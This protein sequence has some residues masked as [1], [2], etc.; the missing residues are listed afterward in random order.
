M[1]VFVS[2]AHEDGTW[3]RSLAGA[4]SRRGLRVF[5]GT[6][7]PRRSTGTTTR[8]WAGSRSPSR[9]TGCSST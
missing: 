9:A 5:L 7:R 1:D 6:T 4:L 3:A 2:Y 8:T